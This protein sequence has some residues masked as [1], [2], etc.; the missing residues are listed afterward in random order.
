MDGLRKGLLVG[1][2]CMETVSEGMTGCSWGLGSWS[3]V[4]ASKNRERHRCSFGWRY[5]SFFVLDLHRI[6]SMAIPELHNFHS[7]NSVIFD[8]KMID[9]IR[10]SWETANFVTGAG[11]GSPISTGHNFKS[12]AEAYL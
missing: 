5:G 12:E 1:S 10:I 2:H 3:L 9:L 8:I 6:R 11:C 4:E 7:I